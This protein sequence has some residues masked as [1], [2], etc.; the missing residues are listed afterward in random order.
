MVA[1]RCL[2]SF[3]FLCY[4]FTA[5]FNY[6]VES[7]YRND[8]C[9]IP[10]K[11]FKRL[12][13]DGFTYIPLKINLSDVIPTI[14][15]NAILLMPVSIAD[16]YKGHAFSDFILNC[17]MANK[18]VYIA[19]YSALIV[20]FNFFYTNFIFNPEKNADFLKKNN[21]FIL[22]EDEE[23]TLLIAFKV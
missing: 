6:F 17:F 2:L 16:F 18:V 12:H 7:S 14:F 15:A 9:S 23:N 4:F 19:A 20:F 10:K 5:T 1:C 3:L 13:S 8:H 11:Q 22:V 21:G